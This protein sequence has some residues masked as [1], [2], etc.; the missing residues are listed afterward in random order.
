MA[1]NVITLENLEAS[2]LTELQG[3]KE[4]QELIV[5]ENPFIQIIDNKTYEEAKKS[6]TTLVTARTTIEKQDKLIASKI[7]SLREKVGDATQELI[8]I[9]LPSEE[10]QQE[11]V[12]RYE[13]IKEAE[14]A[15]KE[16]IEN[17]RKE[18]IQKEIETIYQ[19]EKAKIDS[20][21][22]SG[23]ETLNTDWENGL[24]QTDKSKFEEFSL[25]FT[26]KLQ[27][28]K[29]QFEEKSNILIDK[30]KQRIESEKLAQERAQ[31][32]KEK[33][34]REKTERA[35]REKRE[36]EQ[37]AIDDANKK[38]QQELDAKENE[39]KKA[40]AKR[41]SEIEAEQKAKEEAEN[42][43]KEEAAKKA[44]EKAEAKRIEELKPDK[45][46]AMSYIESLRF[47]SEFPDL[48]DKEVSE[49]LLK[50]RDGLNKS[51]IEFNN[52]ILNIK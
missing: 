47:T 45:E 34:E 6:R 26:S 49:A 23:I 31:F 51:I 11:E 50:I 9:T 1:K 22:F 38:R 19:T 15:E 42:K 37:K 17:E 4:K 43:A 44:K 5:K 18:N 24:F 7:K 21:L 39:L 29:Q 16:R 28:L 52:Q 46:K 33:S 25:Q 14:K 32:E 48:K 12:R 2:S 40:E 30:E 3:W 27:M 10:K 20:L 36:A 41:K 13:A 8:K 35:D